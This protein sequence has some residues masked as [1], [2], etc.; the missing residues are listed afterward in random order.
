[1][2]IIDMSRQRWQRAEKCSDVAAVDALREAIAM[3]EAGEV[4]AESVTVV[5]LV[6][7]ADGDQYVEMLHGGPASTN[8]RIG[9]LARA[10]YVSINGGV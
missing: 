9:M 8:E 6:E 1:M 4:K 3:I 10:Q 2:N 5:L 7:D